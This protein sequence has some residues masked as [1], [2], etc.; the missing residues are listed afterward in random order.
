[1]ILYWKDRGMGSV[2]GFGV[3]EIQ[4]AKPSSPILRGQQITLNIAPKQNPKETEM[5]KYYL[6][7]YI[8]KNQLKHLTEA[9]PE[10]GELWG[11]VP[12]GCFF[13]LFT[14]VGLV[15]LLNYDTNKKPFF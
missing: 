15:D 13:I 8:S 14:A 2:Q 7:M 12:G 11:R 5:H 6:E 10:K 9:T 4:R 1:M 3:V